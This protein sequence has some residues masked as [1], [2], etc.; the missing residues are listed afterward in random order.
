MKKALLT[1]FAMTLLMFTLM[2]SANAADGDIITPVSVRLDGGEMHEDVKALLYNGVT[3]VPLR[4]FCE[5][6][7][8]ADVSWSEKK[9][10]A[11]VRS[12]E[13]EISVTEGT[14]YITVNGRIFYSGR[15]SAII[16]G[17]LYVPVRVMA[18]AYGLDVEWRELLGGGLGY[19]ELT[20]TG[21]RAENAEDIYDS[22]VLYWLSRII[23]AESRGESLVGQIA[24]GNV[25]L[26]RT[27]DK[28]F[29][30]TVYDVIFDNKFGV[31]FT[32]TTNGTIYEDPAESSIIAAKICLEGYSISE[33][34]LYFLNKSIAESLWVTNNRNYVMTL[35]NHAFYS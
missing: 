19:V 14:P 24:V 10:T 7:G 21:K 8:H 2:I 20:S 25:V 13:L 30:D 3:F 5:T 29:P 18:K 6:F 26:N 15:A 33:E 31:Q 4:R 16:E 1:L 34:I 12:T 28:N 32:P 17:I 22:E 27:R 9:R 23:S 35:G 11:K